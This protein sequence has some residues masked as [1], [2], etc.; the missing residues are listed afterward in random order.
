MKK[1]LYL[2]TRFQNERGQ[3]ETEK[4][5]FEKRFGQ[6]GKRLYLCPR[7]RSDKFIKKY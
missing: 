1:R 7:E 6:L 2:C 4:K 5:F 3:E